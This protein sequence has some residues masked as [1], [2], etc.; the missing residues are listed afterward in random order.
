M[1]SASPPSFTQSMSEQFQ[2]NRNKFGHTSPVIPT[3]RSRTSPSSSVFF[4][5]WQWFSR[6]SG[7]KGSFFNF[8]YQRSLSREAGDLNLGLWAKQILYYWAVTP[9]LRL[10]A[11]GLNVMGEATGSANCCLWA[12]D[13]ALKL[14]LPPLSSL[15]RHHNLTAFCA[16]LINLNPRRKASIVFPPP[17][18][19][20]YPE[21]DFDICCQ[22]EGCILKKQER[23]GDPP[24]SVS[25]HQLL[26]YFLSARRNASLHNLQLL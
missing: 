5:A 16:V 3:V 19:R 15:K 10:W 17:T 25:H 21:F 18:H 8:C 12:S 13:L 9:P 22:W 4:S 11:P 26:F 23:G 7:R 20:I 2:M 24:E 6:I 1:V 14:L